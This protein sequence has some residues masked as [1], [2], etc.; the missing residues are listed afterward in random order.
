MK[1]TGR[2]HKNDLWGHATEL[3]QISLGN[4]LNLENN[5]ETNSYINREH[6]TYKP[7]KGPV[8]EKDKTKQKEEIANYIKETKATVKREKR[9]ITNPEITFFKI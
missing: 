8:L 7:I 6:T 9:N 4:Q 3:P 1:R 5:K 2:I